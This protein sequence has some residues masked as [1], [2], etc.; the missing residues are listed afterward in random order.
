MWGWHWDWHWCRY[1]V[2]YSR[3]RKHYWIKKKKT[4]GFE[5]L[6]LALDGFC[7]LSFAKTW[8]NKH[9][10]KCTFGIWDHVRRICLSCHLWLM[11]L[12]MT[13][14]IVLLVT[15]LQ[16]RLLWTGKKKK[17]SSLNLIRS[18][19]STWREKVVRSQSFL[20]RSSVTKGWV[21]WIGWILQ[22]LTL[23]K[24]DT[25]QCVHYQ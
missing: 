3:T 1:I 15:P 10:Q 19:G 16:L 6:L 24:W 23:W 21:K 14:C 7:L 25:K 13:L 20:W 12:V 4:S 8:L 22:L 2:D 18:M 5:S 9:A 17:K 11:T